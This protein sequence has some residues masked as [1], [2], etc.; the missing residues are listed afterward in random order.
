[1][2][3]RCRWGAC[4]PVR[5]L[6]QVPWGQRLSGL[7]ALGPISAQWRP[8][9]LAFLDEKKNKKKKQKH[10]TRCILY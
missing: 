1:M 10:P 3:L 8:L 2:P 4:D 9:A 6:P 5:L 7:L